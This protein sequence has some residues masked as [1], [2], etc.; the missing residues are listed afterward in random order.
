MSKKTTSTIPYCLLIRPEV[1]TFYNSERVTSINAKRGNLGTDKSV[2]Y[3]NPKVILPVP[4]KKL[5]HYP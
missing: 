3:K 2:P 5:P 1:R 4:Y